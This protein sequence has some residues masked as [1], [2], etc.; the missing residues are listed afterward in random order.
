ML[1]HGCV[2]RRKSCL[3]KLLHKFQV[4]RVIVWHMYTLHRDCHHKSIVSIHHHRAESLPD[5]D[6]LFHLQT[7]LYRVNFL[8]QK[9]EQILH[10]SSRITSKYLKVKVKVKALSHVRLCA[11]PLTVA[12]QDPPSMEFSRQQY[13]SGSP[14]PPPGDPPDPEIEPGSPALQ[15]DALPSEPPGKP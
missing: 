9:F 14:F 6:A 2:I 10:G 5:T 1:E 11:T 4:N 7:F 3:L 8:S 15:A 13:W 12:Y